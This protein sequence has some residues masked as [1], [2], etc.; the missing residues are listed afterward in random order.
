MEHDVLRANDKVAHANYHLLKEHGIRSVDFMGSVG[1][2]K[3]TLIIE[4]GKRLKAQGKR[5]CVIAGDVIGDDDYKRFTAAGL[6]SVNLNTG[7][8]CHL[9][10]PQV[11][12]VLES[13]DLDAYDIIFIENVG[14]LVCPADF[15]L[16]TDFRVAVISV[17]EGDDMVRKH[18][19]V[20]LHSDFA[21]LNKADI[22]S[23][24]DVDPE[25]IERDYA[26]LTGG[27]KPMFRTAAKKG[28]GVD[29]VLGFFNF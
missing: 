10:A 1:S 3:T 26:K 29:D 27:L 20:F 5:V 9:E 24:V 15:N 14:N 18:H 16:G 7:K 8:E 25:V 11:K 13:M 19:Q 17:T 2:G 22:A 6:D 28:D 12:R 23:A 21:V 4:L